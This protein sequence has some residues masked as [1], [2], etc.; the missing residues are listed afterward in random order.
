[1]VIFNSAMAKDRRNPC[2]SH[3]VKIE[4]GARG[5]LCGIWFELL[6]EYD[7]HPTIIL[8]LQS[9]ISKDIL[10]LESG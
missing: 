3:E 7:R 6:F 5:V 2:I 1:M 10:F 4:I 8:I 9:F